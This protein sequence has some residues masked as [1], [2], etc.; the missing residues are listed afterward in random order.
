MIKHENYNCRATDEQ[1]HEHLVY[2]NWLHNEGLDT[3]QGY[4]CDAGHTR[5]YIDKNFDVWSGECKNNHLGNALTDWSP[6]TNTVCNRT[7]CT[8]CTDDLITRKYQNDI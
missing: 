5:F 8:G 7:T 1:G 4:H 6:K 3:W 2:A